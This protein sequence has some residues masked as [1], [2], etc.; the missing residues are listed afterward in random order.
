MHVFVVG[1]FGCVWSCGGLLAV[2]CVHC[3]A[4]GCGCDSGFGVAI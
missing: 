2:M 3:L 4:G 1:V